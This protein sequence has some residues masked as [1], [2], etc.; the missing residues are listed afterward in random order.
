VNLEAVC[1]W[2]TSDTKHYRV[3]VPP[4]KGGAKRGGLAVKKV[5]GDV[6]G[7]GNITIKSYTLVESNATQIDMREYVS[8]AYVLGVASATNV[9]DEI[10]PGIIDIPLDIQVGNNQGFLISCD[11]ATTGT[12]GGVGI[13]T[14]GR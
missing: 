11:R 13:L 1:F 8:P 7:T 4:A 3:Y 5:F 6:K 14:K 10:G 9:A 2:D 12:T